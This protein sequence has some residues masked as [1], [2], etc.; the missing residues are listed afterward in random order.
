MKKILRDEANFCVLEGFLSELLREEV[1]IE[2]ILESE[3][4]REHARDTEN[5]FHMNAW[6]GSNE[7]ILVE[8]QFRRSID[9]FHRPLFEV[10][11]AV[12]EHTGG[13]YLDIKKI[14]FDQ[15][16]LL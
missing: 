15:Y 14:I 3:S 10:T 16:P 13:N 6:L 7:F 8:I 5:R 9:F 4:N 1:K 12:T 11:K 2:E